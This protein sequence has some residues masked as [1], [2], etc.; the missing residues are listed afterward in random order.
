MQ[1]RILNIIILFTLSLLAFMLVAFGFEWVYE[2]WLLEE[3]D[4]WI[5]TFIGIPIVAILSAMLLFLFL[6]AVDFEQEDD[7]EYRHFH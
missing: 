3:F 6:N 7:E 2:M 4:S 1:E 5:V